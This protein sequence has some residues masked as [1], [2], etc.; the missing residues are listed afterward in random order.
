MINILVPIAGKSIFFENSQYVFPKPLIEIDGVPMIEHVI[1]NLNTIQSP[2]KFTFVLS[3]SDCSRFHLDSVVQL[4]APGCEIVRLDG[5]TKGAVCSALMAIEQVNHPQELVIV[6]ADQIIH[7][8]LDT[9]LEDFR[10]QALDAGVLCFDS[11]HPR[12]SFVRVDEEGQ[13]LEAA[14]KRPLSRHAIAGF[15][16]FRSGED[17][18]R[19]AMNSIRKDANVNGTYYIAPVL[20][21]LVL[22]NK[23][24]GM[25]EIP[26][27]S[28]DT[29]YSPQKIE[30]YERRQRT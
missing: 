25:L 28:Y 3:N 9:I 10:K 13:I 21:E 7:S 17:F 26:K 2:K 4:L 8:E 5:E 24:L 30:E 18:V 11:V 15:Y 14:E 1:A 19:A 12:W 22:E 27:Q 23:R 16:Y 29:F 6:N 20:N